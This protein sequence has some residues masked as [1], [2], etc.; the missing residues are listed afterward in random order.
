M[1]EDISP[2]L[3]DDG[4]ADPVG[5]FNFGFQGNDRIQ[6][7]QQRIKADA[8]QSPDI[9]CGNDIIHDGHKKAG[10]QHGKRT[11]GKHEEGC[12]EHILLKR[13]DI[14]AET[15]QLPQVKVVFHDLVD[16]VF[17]TCHINVPPLPV[18]G[19]DA[20]RPLRSSRC[21]QAA[22]YGFP[23]PRSVRDPEPESDRHPSGRKYGRR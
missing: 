21:F 9:P 2:Q 6:D 20:Q 3:V 10:D 5:D 11:G 8:D 23:V 13:K 12:Q 4:L 7:N 15:F 14:M 22:L 18:Y 16:I 17:I 19:T 1:A